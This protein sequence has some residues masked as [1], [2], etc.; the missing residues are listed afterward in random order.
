[1]NMNCDR[2]WKAQRKCA[3]SLSCYKLVESNITYVCVCVCVK[4]ADMKYEKQPVNVQTAFFSTY[5][6]IM[7]LCQFFYAI[8]LYIVLFVMVYN[9]IFLRLL[10]PYY[11]VTFLITFCMVY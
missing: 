1:M 6:F 11:I 8:L 10:M 4:N 5:I 7:T 3:L 2:K 9:S